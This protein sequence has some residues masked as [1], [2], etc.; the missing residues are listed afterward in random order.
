MIN[1]ILIRIKIIQLLYAYRNNKMNEGSESPLTKAQVNSIIKH[2][3]QE[4]IDSLNQ[5]YDLY[6]YLLQLIVELHLYAVKRIEAGLNKLRPTEEERNPN[7]RFINNTLSKQL[8]ANQQ[9]AAYVKEN[10][11][12]W[13]EEGDLIKML[14]NKMVEADFFKAYMQETERDYDKDK[15]LWRQIIKKI[16][17]P[18]TILEE[19][20]EEINLYWNDDF[21]TVIS[22]VEKTIKRFKEENGAQ[23]ELLEK[24]RDV[25]DLDY[26]KKLLSNAILQQS[27]YE[28]MVQS[29]A[30][31]WEVERIAC[32]DMIIL[33][34]AITEVKTFPT[35]PVNVTM[36]EFIEISKYYS[37]EKS[38]TFI[39]GILDKIVN[40]LRA[41]G[42]LIKV[43]I[44]NKDN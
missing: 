4:L 15:L 41:E 35:I 29:V 6:H 40:D 21:E 24:Y 2:A 8:V 30:K 36:N 7:R 13:A 20:L 32:M 16:L 22:F 33:Q 18:S 44:F 19:R 26:A 28:K 12:S 31:N 38:S 23:Q 34:A 11:I 39:N 27:E 1:R 5:T 37:T 10:G 42:S 9:L 14:Y 25:E 43:G 17:I 3:E